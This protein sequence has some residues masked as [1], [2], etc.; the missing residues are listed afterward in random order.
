MLDECSVALGLARAGVADRRTDLFLKQ[1]QTYL[2][3][4]GPEAG[5]EESELFTSQS[6]AELEHV[7]DAPQ[8]E[9]P[10]LKQFILPAGGQTACRIHQARTAVR[11]LERHMALMRA[12][13]PFS[14]FFLAW[15]N[16]LSDALFLLARLANRQEDRAEE[17]VPPLP[18]PPLQWERDESG[19]N[20][21]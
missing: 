17:L 16:R 20:G 6:V 13:Y 4:A 2:L 14:P 3:F 21:A 15:I 19:T 12:D 11:R 10:Q 8:E 1:V 18:L 9:L 7:L 5:K